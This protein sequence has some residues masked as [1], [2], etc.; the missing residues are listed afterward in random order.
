V[1][2][3]ETHRL[4]LRLFALQDVEHVHGLI[5]ADPEVAVPWMGHVLS[6][7]EVRGP[8]A[9]LSQIARASDEPGLLAVDRVADHSMIGIAGVIPLRRTED[10]DRFD[11]PDALDRVGAVPGREEAELV[12]ALGRAYWNRGYATE[13][14]TAVINIGFHSL[15]FSRVVV[16]I[17]FGNDRALALV[18]RLGFRVVPNGKADPQSGSS[19]PGS[20]GFLDGPAGS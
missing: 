13:A 14:A 1:K 6:L 4:N 18:G 20:I 9:F 5:Y 11:P 17:G 7:Q 15:R 10:R 2:V 16:S 12:M 8:R 3:A 19:S